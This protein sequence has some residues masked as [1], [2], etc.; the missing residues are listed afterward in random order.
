M[1]PVNTG[2]EATQT[3]DT[4]MSASGPDRQFAPRYHKSADRGEA[5]AI[6]GRLDWRS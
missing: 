4:S 6:A 3:L 5:A 1:S 2:R